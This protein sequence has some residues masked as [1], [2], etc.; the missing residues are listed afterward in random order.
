MHRRDQAGDALGI[1]QRQLLRHQFADDQRQVG[2]DRDDDAEADGVAIP[3]RSPMAMSQ[4]A[5]RSPSEVPE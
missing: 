1:A 4:A 3:G 5:S 2:D